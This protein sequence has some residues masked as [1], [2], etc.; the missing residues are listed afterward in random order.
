MVE[1]GVA[2]E[3]A[4]DAV[5]ED[6]ADA[7]ELGVGRQLDRIETALFL[8]DA[9]AVDQGAGVEGHRPAVV[10]RMDQPGAEIAVLDAA[11]GAQRDDVEAVGGAG[12][13]G[14]RQA[15]QQRGGDQ[16]SS[17]RHDQCSSPPMTIVGTLAV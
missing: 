9:Q 14:D 4:L 5:G 13:A 6:V 8:G 2:D 3:I 10:V 11:Q 17:W 1:M 16:G 7:A 15:G 12:G